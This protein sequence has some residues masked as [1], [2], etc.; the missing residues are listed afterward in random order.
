MRVFRRLPPPDQRLPCALTIGNFD[1]VHL[2][3]RALL[4]RLRERAAE[5]GGPSCVLTFEPHPREFFAARNPVIGAPT[6]IL[7]LRNKLEALEAEGIDRVCVAHFNER[8]AALDAQTFVEQVIAAGL[9]TR[10][11]LIGDDFRFG[12]RR[13]GDFA[14]LEHMAPVCGFELERMDTVAL[15]AV[16]VSSSAIRGALTE[17]DFER[18][19]RL[20]GRPYRISGHV[21][22]GRKLGRALGFPTL[23]LRI[24]HGRPAVAGVFV[25]RVHG[26]GSEPLPGVASLGTRPAVERGGRLLLEVHIF[27]L[28]R[29]AYG[30]LVE[31]EFLKR[32]RSEESYDSLE[33]LTA[34]IQRDA[35][36]A[37]AYFQKE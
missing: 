25:V 31:V 4:A 7:T 28:E 20:L 14:L 35:Q 1:G 23:N 18:A 33:A 11:L 29:D 32:L 2:G 15:D 24:P 26:L 30:A 37:R 9:R 16:R 36:A 6:R 12:A 13:S 27:D 3:H 19:T 5:L 21:I 17:G 8:F 10:H 22:H 34:Q